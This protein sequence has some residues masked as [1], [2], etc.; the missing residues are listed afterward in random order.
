MR[1]HSA[2]T[3]IV[4]VDLELVASV[5]L[6]LELVESVEMAVEPAPRRYPKPCHPPAVPHSKRNQRKPR[7]GRRKMKVGTRSALQLPKLYREEPRL[8]GRVRLVPVCVCVD[9]CVCV[10]VCACVIC[11][12]VCVCMYLCLCV[13][14][15]ASECV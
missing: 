2:A 7:R 9:V 12:Q 11:E 6:E 13:C 14:E 4:P 10:F 1:P 5:E 8:E 15:C 3:E